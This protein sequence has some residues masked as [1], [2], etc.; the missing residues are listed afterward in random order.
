MHVSNLIKLFVCICL[1]C[2][3]TVSTPYVSAADITSDGDT[4]DTPNVARDAVIIVNGQKM[5][6]PN[7]MAQRR[8]ARWLLPVLGLARALGD[9]AAIS[10]ATRTIS[11]RRQTGA[12]AEFDAN[13][14]VVR[15]N[16][17]MILTVSNVAEI[18][19]PPNADE[20]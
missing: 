7:S 9:I 6:G 10:T 20:I 12:S 15:E 8:G 4:D 3:F 19:F 2:V 16:G 13:L 5:T 17:S 11:V 14:G 18:V 1:A